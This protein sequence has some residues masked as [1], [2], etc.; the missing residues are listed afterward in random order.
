M[1]GAIATKSRIAKEN[2]DQCNFYNAL[3]AINEMNSDD[4]L[5]NNDLELV[6]ESLKNN[7]NNNNNGSAIET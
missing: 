5:N 3:P 7:N 1:V 4:F 6:L 2:D